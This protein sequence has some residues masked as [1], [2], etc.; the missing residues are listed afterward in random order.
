M[1]IAGL[2][3]PVDQAGGPAPMLSIDDVTAGEGPVAT[4]TFM[5][6]VSLAST[7]TVS[8]SYA[9]APGTASAF[10][11]VPISGTLSFDPGV[12]TQPLVID[13]Q[14][15]SLDE[16][17]E[18]FSVLL[19][20]PAEAGIEDGEGSGTLT[21]DDAPPSLSIASDIVVEGFGIRR[22][23]IRVTLDAP[24]GRDVSVDYTVGPGSA[25]PGSDFRAASGTLQFA[26]G[27]TTRTLFVWTKGDRA[28]EPNE[29][30]LVELQGAVNATLA[31]SQATLTILDDDPPP[32]PR[33]TP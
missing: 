2:T 20:S 24:S 21:D 25:S 22:V 13:L 31:A 3:F 30:I 12:T 27:V 8:V 29:S 32:R 26:P 19:F 5:V 1:T 18:T 11:F 6:S 33:T 9:T 17:D 28:D 16:D 10:D 4:A 15:D 7:D 23:P 14:D